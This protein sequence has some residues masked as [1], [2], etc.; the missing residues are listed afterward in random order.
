[1]S[2]SADIAICRKW[3]DGGGRRWHQG[4]DVPEDIHKCEVVIA[5]E[6]VVGLD[7]ALREIMGSEVSVKTKDLSQRM[8]DAHIEYWLE[9][10]DLDELGGR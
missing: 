10:V 7:D 2:I 9:K 5:A 3:W 4:V 6:S 1:M 8:F